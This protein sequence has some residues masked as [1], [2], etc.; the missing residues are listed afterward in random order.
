MGVALDEGPVPSQ[1][2]MVGTT[3]Y[4]VNGDEGDDPITVR[5]CP[6]NEPPATGPTTPGVGPGAVI[7][8]AG[9]GAY[10]LAGQVVGV[11]LEP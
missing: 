9:R 7:T 11:S 2:L 4:W 3:L 6:A 10:W 8:L 5:R 1:L